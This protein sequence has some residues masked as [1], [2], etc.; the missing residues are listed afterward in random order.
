[1]LFPSFP[2]LFVFLPI[3]LIGA[4]AVTAG[5]GEGA[6]RTW[7]LVA[8]LVFYVW[9]H[10][11][12][13][14]VLVAS[15]A[16]NA[17]VATRLA[18]GLPARRMMLLFGVGANL[19]LL[20]YFKY[21]AFLADTW[22]AITGEAVT[23][24]PISLPLAISFFTFQQIAYLVDRYRG[25]VGDVGWRHYALFVSFFPQLIAGPIVH[26]REVGVQ[27]KRPGLG[28]F[29]PEDVAVGATFLAFGLFKKVILA[30]G[31][32]PYADFVFA[33]AGN[34]APL[35]I[36]EAW[37][38]ALLFT[39]QIYFDFS[40][41]SDM[42]IGLARLFGIR[43]PE[44]FNS[45]YKASNIVDFWSRWN[46]TLSRFLRDYLYFPLFFSK[47]FGGR[48][49]GKR[50]FAVMVTML[51]GGLWHGAGW[52]YVLWGALHGA[53]MVIHG[54]WRWLRAA[55]DGGPAGR[56]GHVVATALTFLAV[57]ASMV[58]FRAASFETAVA[59][60]HSMFG[61]NGFALPGRLEGLF[62]HA[63]A[64]EA[65]G[66]DFRGAFRNQVLAW[67]PALIWIVVEAFVVFAAPNTQ[68]LLMRYGPTLR[69]NPPAPD[70]PLP[71]LRWE[72]TPAW[73][74]LAAG[75]TLLAILNLG[76]VEE[77]VYFQF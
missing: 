18:P 27:L 65:L 2:F 47:R 38:G 11:P 24:G 34:G 7:L 35:T 71:R 43:L 17:L 51:L 73:A 46:M 20:G 32:A 33:A 26:F 29:A 70:A 57:T 55:R 39:F 1:M 48:G 15:L 54:G 68:E 72:P 67:Q 40:A 64:L 59:M 23:I 50:V 74:L 75:M 16:M 66:V 8:S 61:G 19:A 10:P 37:M 42:A 52:T 31:I 12:D 3:T 22:S 5:L 41:Y 44:N 13:L 4:R 14:A 62:E 77:F 60:L 25:V 36:A 53:F 21:A 28:R 76:Q 56:A 6:V 63:P 45:P 9:W 49:A 30:D 69:R 58:L